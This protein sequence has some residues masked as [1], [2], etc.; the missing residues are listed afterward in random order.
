MK[1]KIFIIIF[2][3]SSCSVS[4]LK[5]N[6]VDVK[7]T[8]AK[9]IS[10]LEAKKVLKDKSFIKDLYP[11]PLSEFEETS[12]KDTPRPRQL[13]SAASSNEIRLHK[14]GEI[15]WVYLGLEPSTAWPMTEQFIQTNT[16]IDLATTNSDLGI[17][18]TK[19]FEFNGL[20]SKYTFKIERGLQQSST[21][22]FLSQLFKRDS[23]WEILPLSQSN[24]EVLTSEFYEFLSTTGPIT[25]TSL[26][27]LNLNASNKTEV[28]SDVDGFTKIKLRINFPRAWAA[29]R[30]SLQLAGLNVIDENRDEGKFFLE[31]KRNRTILDR[32]P[33]TKEVE[34]IIKELKPNECLI[35]TNL[36]SEDIEISEDIISQIN[37]ALS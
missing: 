27:A 14:L 18:E 9:S 36:D 17:I 34:L 6:E 20:E 24:L 26:V 15:R 35:F 28:F 30:R 8:E 37:Q 3:L 5:K 11:I 32:G 10:L 33:D 25:G 2:L 1:Y 31:V 22:I 13:F 16:K 29:T 12:K 23:S 19:S 4:P 21:E 7:Q